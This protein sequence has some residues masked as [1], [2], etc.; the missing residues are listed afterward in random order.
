MA[1]GQGITRAQ[2]RALGRA[3]MALSMLQLVAFLA[4]ATRRSYVAVAVPVGLALGVVSG[5]AFWI[6]YTMATANWDD[7]ADFPSPE[8]TPPATE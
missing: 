2:S 6:G 1:G 4:A 7:P 5:V 8:P 3:L